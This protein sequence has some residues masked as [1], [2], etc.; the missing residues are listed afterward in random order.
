MTG[1]LKE[2]EIKTSVKTNF[3]FNVHMLY[4]RRIAGDLRKK[5]DPI[6][7]AGRLFEQL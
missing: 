7:T 4:D 5:T 6:T 2:K 1:V 3:L